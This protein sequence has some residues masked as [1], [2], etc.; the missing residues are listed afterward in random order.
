M[1]RLIT[2]S[3]ALAIVAAATLSGCSSVAAGMSDGLAAGAD[4]SGGQ[5]SAAWADSEYGT[6]EAVNVSGTGDSVVPLPAGAQGGLVT[7]THTGSSNFAL[8]VIDAAN[9]PTI[10]LLANTIGNYSGITAYGLNS[11]LGEPGTNIQ[12][13]ADGPWTIGITPLSSAPA[14][15]ESGSGSA[16]FVYDGDAATKTLTHDGASN[17]SVV[18]YNTGMMSMNL[19]VNEIGPYQGAVPF[20]SGPSIVTILADGNWAI[21]AS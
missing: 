15:P 20:V 8:Q 1:K 19:L 4:G 7:A 11:A 14:L 3:A 6:F 16:V 2:I 10:D 13:T 12:V 5:T 9:A 17:F 21:A 18:Q